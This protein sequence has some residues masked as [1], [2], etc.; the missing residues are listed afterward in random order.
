MA[1]KAKSVGSMI[2]AFIIRCM[3]YFGTIPLNISGLDK[4][5]DAPLYDVNSKGESKLQ[6]LIEALDR[7]TFARAMAPDLF[8]VIDRLTEE[9]AKTL[10]DWDKALRYLNLAR[11]VLKRR[12]AE[13]VTKP[14]PEKDD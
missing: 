4:L 10:K 7:K 2:R 14:K 5:L 8:R 1:D 11:E 3:T 13:A 9:H 6:R 12:A